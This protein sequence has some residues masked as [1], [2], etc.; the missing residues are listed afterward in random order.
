[1]V[2]GCIADNKHSQL[3]SF[4]GTNTADTYIETLCRNLVPF[5]KC[6]PTEITN[7]F[8]FQQDNERIHT[9]NKTQDW[10]AKQKFTVMEWPPNSPDMNPIEHS[11][12]ELKAQLHT[13]YP[14]T[15]MLRGGPEKVQQVLE[16]HL[17]VVWNDIV[18]DRIMT[19][20]RSMPNRAAELY[21]AKGWYTGY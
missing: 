2:W 15:Y 17:K 10:F 13:R 16:E 12:R 14:D 6:V 4:R 8:I 20:I 9:A 19:L 7:N 18:Q 1:M 3:V 5:I 21:C 11:W